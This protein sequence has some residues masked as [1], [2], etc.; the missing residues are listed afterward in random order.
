MSFFPYFI[1]TSSVF[2]ILSWVLISFV[3][4]TLNLYHVVTVSELVLIKGHHVSHR[5]SSFCSCFD[6]AFFN[7]ISSFV[8][9]CLPHAVIVFICFLYFSSCF[10]SYFIIFH[11]ISSCAIVFVPLLSGFIF[12][13][14]VFY[15][16]IV[17]YMFVFC[18]STFVS[19]VF[20]I[21]PSIVPYCFLCFIICLIN[22]HQFA[23]VSL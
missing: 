17:V 15:F 5:F 6:I 14:H 20:I 11:H 23:I 13:T 9:S 4:Q 1:L 3:S 10:S 2:I 18:F 12:L 16:I 22:F 21:V 7:H 19:S 8:S